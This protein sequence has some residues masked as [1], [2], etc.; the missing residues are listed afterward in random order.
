ML[1]P[2]LGERVD[3]RIDQSRRGTDRASLAGA[4]NAERVRAAWDNIVGELDRRQIL[5]PRQAIIGQRAGEKL[6][7]F[8]VENSAFEHCLAYSLRDAALHLSCEQQRVDHN[9]E[10]I[11]HQIAQNVDMPGIRLYL[12]LADMTAIG[13]SG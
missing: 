6:P 11:D 12:D 4:L 3:G 8:W 5:G 1:D 13:K 9:A 2:D 7:G 10:I